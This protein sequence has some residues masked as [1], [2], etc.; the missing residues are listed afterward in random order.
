MYI[1]RC[2]IDIDM[3]DTF[4]DKTADIDINITLFGSDVNKKNVNDFRDYLQS[5]VDNYKVNEI[6]QPKQMNQPFLQITLD[7]VNDAPKIIYND[8]EITGRVRYMKYGYVTETND[9]RML[10][11]PYFDMQ[12]LSRDGKPFVKRVGFGLESFV[13]NVIKKDR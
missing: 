12:Y 4:I 6:I 5:C 11:S 7:S 8:E 9:E 13:D 10:D 3:S 2:G 1:Q